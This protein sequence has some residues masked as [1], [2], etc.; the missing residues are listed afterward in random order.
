M[1]STLLSL[2]DAICIDQISLYFLGFVG[3]VFWPQRAWSEVRREQVCP[4]VYSIKCMLILISVRVSPNPSP[5]I[6]D[7]YPPFPTNLVH[8]ETLFSKVLPWHLWPGSSLLV[9]RKTKEREKYTFTHKAKTCRVV[10]LLQSTSLV[11]RNTDNKGLKLSV[12]LLFCLLK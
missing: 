3:R 2:I 9:R 10:R 12:S 4:V 11:A 8:S 7:F 5:K 6:S 1:I